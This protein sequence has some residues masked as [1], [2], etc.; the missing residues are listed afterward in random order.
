MV[1]LA[2]LAGGVI[3]AINPAKRIHQA[4]DT[5]IQNDIG[6]IATALQ[7]YY[8]E[9]QSYP[10][11]TAGVGALVTNGDLKQVPTPP[12]GSNAS[13]QY[14]AKE[15]NCAPATATLCTEARVYATM[16]DPV[17]AGSTW[18]W[19]SVTGQASEQTVANCAP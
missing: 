9:N 17:V 4:N 16:L 2:V 13:Y 12:S 11:D 10:S 8:T 5:R 15:A 14:D 6:Q 18:C 3:L 1:V 7:A 19:R